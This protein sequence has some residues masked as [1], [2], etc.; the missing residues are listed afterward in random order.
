MR[1]DRKEEDEQEE[2]EGERYVF[3]RAII[4]ALSFHSTS[5]VNVSLFMQISLITALSLRVNL[6]HQCAHRQSQPDK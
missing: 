2:E 6:I 3:R 4:E 1:V 5:G